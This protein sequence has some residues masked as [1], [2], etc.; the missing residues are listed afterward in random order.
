LGKDIDMRIIMTANFFVRSSSSFENFFL[1]IIE[2]PR[3]KR[4]GMCSL[5]PV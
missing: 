4:Q 2:A 1:S 5:L 3:R